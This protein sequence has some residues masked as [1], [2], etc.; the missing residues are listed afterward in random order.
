[1][2]RVGRFLTVVCLLAIVAGC[3]GKSEKEK[4]A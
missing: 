3:G 2:I 4:Q 1:M